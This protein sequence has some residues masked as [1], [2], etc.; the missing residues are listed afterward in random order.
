MVA[1]DGIE[2]EPLWRR[3]AVL[4]LGADRRNPEPAF[5]EGPES[6]RGRDRMVARTES[7]L[8]RSGG[9]RP[10]F[11]RKP[12]GEIPPGKGGLQ[13]CD[14][15]HYPVKAKLMVMAIR[16]IF[17]LCVYLLATLAFGSVPALA[18]QS[19]EPSTDAIFADAP[20]EKWH[21]G[22]SIGRSMAG[23]SVEGILLTPETGGQHQGADTG[24]GAAEAQP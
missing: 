15:G 16:P 17:R 22:T 5:G 11:G 23:S 18:F 13:D 6:S 14:C 21:P 19:E 10:F 20:F 7:N 3:E 4:W 9:V 1:R 2:L 12:T 8:S 24:H